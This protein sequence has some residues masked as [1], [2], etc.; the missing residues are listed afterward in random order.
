MT[1]PHNIAA[2]SHSIC[3]G[4]GG[5]LAEIPQPAGEGIRGEW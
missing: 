2:V 3:R 4:A 5:Q 1:C